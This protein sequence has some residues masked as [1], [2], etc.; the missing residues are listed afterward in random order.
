MLEKL[1]TPQNLDAQGAAPSRLIAPP[2]HCGALEHVSALDWT[3]EVD[4]GR[5]CSSLG[6]FVSSMRTSTRWWNNCSPRSHPRAPS[7]L[8]SVTL[9]SLAPGSATG[10]GL[11]ICRV[12]RR[13][14]GL[15]PDVDRSQS[16][17]AS[18]SLADL[19]VGTVHQGIPLAYTT[20]IQSVIQ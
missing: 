18:L 15:M 10:G 20:V 8:A 12:E 5:H 1:R 7:L 11:A 3:A 17:P 9:A 19:P 13:P 14:C 6:G 2:G 4:R 16:W